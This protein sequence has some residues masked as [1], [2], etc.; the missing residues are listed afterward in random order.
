VRTNRRR[1]LAV[2]YLLPGLYLLTIAFSSYLNHCLFNLHTT[3]V[4]SEHRL[5]GWVLE[6][7]LL[8]QLCAAAVAPVDQ[9][10][11]SGDVATEA[12]RL[13]AAWEAFDAHL[14]KLARRLGGQT[15]P[16][17]LEAL[18][19]HLNL[20]RRAMEEV[21]RQAEGVLAAYRGGRNGQAAE[22]RATLE[23]WHQQAD[24]A[25]D[26]AR[27]HLTAIQTETANR[28]LARADALAQFKWA[29]GA[30]VVVL[31][32][33]AFL[34]GHRLAQRMDRQTVQREQLI[35]QLTASEESLRHLNETLEQR[36]AE[37]TAQLTT[38]NT[39]LETEIAHRRRAEDQARALFESAPDGLLLVG[40]AGEILQVNDQTDRLF[41]YAREEL[42]G[43]PVEI[44]LPEQTRARHARLR[45][46]YARAPQR[47]P[48]GNRLDLRARRKDGT[49]FPVDI[50]LSPIATDAGACVVCVVRDIT[51]RRQAELGREQLIAELRRA[52]AEV[53]EL[54]GLLPICAACKKVRDDKGYWNELEVYLTHHSKAQFSHGLCPECAK[55]YFAELDRLL[56]RSPESSPNSAPPAR[57]TL[58]AMVPPPPTNSSLGA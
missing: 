13:Q 8:D 52:L 17:P 48:M 45:L 43:Q 29:I 49:E 28:Q 22:L 33:A 40:P 56:P 46:D 44:L 58:G 30:L 7:S 26:Q 21:K 15:A 12:A 39:T 57:S 3:T 50:S 31:V 9:V 1:W 11:V 18:L 54:S 41:G 42:L 35:R 24:E 37:R 14:T 25:L 2:F 53:K 47:R 19:T 6:I 36:V 20:A 55:P 34:T 16:V 38:A 51:E 4:R 32:G 27:D 5:A 10:F 23:H